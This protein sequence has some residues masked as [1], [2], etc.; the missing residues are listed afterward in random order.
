MV[1]DVGDGGI[2]GGFCPQDAFGASTG[3]PSR[4]RGAALVE[5]ARGI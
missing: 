5:R 4:A 2:E 3:P 1:F